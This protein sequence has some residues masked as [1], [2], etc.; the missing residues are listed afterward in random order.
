MPAQLLEQQL[1]KGTQWGD[2]RGIGSAI[3]GLS[4]SIRPPD[5][6][7]PVNKPIVAEGAHG[8][9][10]IIRAGMNIW[11]ETHKGE[12]PCYAQV[13]EPEGDPPAIVIDRLRSA[14]DEADSFDYGQPEGFKPLR[15][16]IAGHLN[17]REIYPAPVDSKSIIVTPGSKMA[18]FMTGYALVGEGDRVAVNEMVYPGHAAAVLMNGGQLVG[19]RVDPDNG[20]EL[21]PDQIAETLE[22]YKPKVIWVC[23]PDNPRGGVWRVDQARPVVKYMLSNPD[24]T[25]A[26]DIIYKDLVLKNDTRNMVMFSTIPAISD[27]V[28]TNDGVS[29]GPKGTGLRVGYIAVPPGQERLRKN[30]IAQANALYAGTSILIAKGVTEAFLPQGDAS[31]ETHRS[32]LIQKKKI[33]TDLMRQIPGIKINDPAGAFYV[34]LDIDKTG[35]T[36]DGFFEFALKECG[37]GTLPAKVF[38]HDVMDVE[39]NPLLR[40]EIAERTVRWSFAGPI[41]NQVAGLKR[42]HDT[43]SG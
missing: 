24:T 4:E 14:L 15:E 1:E 27:R 34:L 20:Y 31:I 13:G 23:N 42:L 11:Q 29:K 26:Q 21:D 5:V 10:P 30:L 39:G 12:L 40:R 22:K 41:D 7:I 43:L 33:V 38:G 35:M 3:L 9:G 37:V 8:Y 2:Y 28:I 19:M 6:I 16:A 36:A 32:E 17:R 25:I 18:G